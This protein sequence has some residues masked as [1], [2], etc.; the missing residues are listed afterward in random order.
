V[1]SVCAAVPA[2]ADWYDQAEGSNPPATYS[3][4]V[5]GEYTV[6]GSDP[7]A[8]SGLGIG[9]KLGYGVPIGDAVEGGSFDEFVKGAIQSEF[10]LNY[11]ITPSIIIGGYAGLGI[12]LL[13]D[14]VDDFC[15]GD[16]DCS[17]F[18]LNVG[19]AA[20]YRIMPGN[21]VN[22]WVGANFGIEWTTLSVSSEYADASSS[23]FGIGFGPSLGV[24]FELKRWGIGPYFSYQ[25]G[26]FLSGDVRAEGDNL[27]ASGSDEIENRAFHGWLL[28]GVRARYTFAH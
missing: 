13:P 6:E 14:A 20:E 9:M 10:A 26:K 5:G 23:L 24:D 17:I 18:L 27:G 8:G 25:A 7:S 11:G 4:P 15:G 2:Q 3:S 22:P 21:L 12:G 1:L 28:F 16:V 19:M